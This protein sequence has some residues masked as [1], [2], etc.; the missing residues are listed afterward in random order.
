M[1]IELTGIVPR[2]ERRLRLVFSGPLAAGAFG[3]PAPAYYV[4]DNE[5]GQGPSPSVDAAIIVAGAVNNVELALDADLVE[6]ALYR[7]TA[8]DVPGA[9]ATT[10]TSAS[11]QQFRFGIPAIRPNREP[12]ASD[13]ELVLYGRDVLWTGDDYGETP[14]GDLATI[15]G[16]RNVQAAFRRRMLGA[17]LAWAPEYSPRAREFV[18]AP[19][20]TV[21]ALRGRI[22]RQ[23]LRDDR[24]ESITARLVLD[25]ETPTDSYFEIT[26]TFRGGRAAEAIDLAIST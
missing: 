1:T 14:E 16:L 18:D 2:H 10:S 24:I 21:G 13:A 12:K 23:A 22:E 4:V 9:D 19:D 25:D 26:P 7:V 5:D 8:V 20:V 11:D 15:D 6:G 17:P 3:S